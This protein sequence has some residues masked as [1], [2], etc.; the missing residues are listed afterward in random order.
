[1]VG[2]PDNNVV[3]AII[4]HNSDFAVIPEPSTYALIGGIICLI[5]VA[6]LEDA[7]NTNIF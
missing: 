7:N 3:W 6:L 1:M 4:D 2:D 5:S